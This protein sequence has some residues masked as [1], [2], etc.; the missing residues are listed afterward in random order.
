MDPTDS[1]LAVARVAGAHGVRGELRC[2]LLTDFPER[3]KHTHRLYSGES[4]T[5]LDVERARLQGGRAAILKISGIDS[6]NDAESLRGQMLYVPEAEAVPLSKGS[7]FW[8]QIV[9]LRVR[10]TDGQDLGTVTEILQT[11]SNDVYAVRDDHRE[12]LI[13]AIKDVVKGIDLDAGVM[14]IEMVE[15]LFS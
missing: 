3:L 6:R 13:P 11:G 1:F 7:Y 2:E 4:H 8:H 10:S 12:V 15:G 5:P 14:T 9:G